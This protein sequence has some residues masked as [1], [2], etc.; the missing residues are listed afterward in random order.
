M[1]V[2]W[3]INS[4]GTGQYETFRHLSPVTPGLWQFHSVWHSIVPASAAPVSDDLCCQSGVQ[5]IEVRLDLSASSLTALA[6][7]SGE[8]PEQSLS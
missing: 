4:A 1:G 8:N 6:A 2:Q 3:W 7:G 5:V